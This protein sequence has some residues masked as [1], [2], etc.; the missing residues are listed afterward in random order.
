LRLPPNNR[1][2]LHFG[3][4]VIMLAVNLAV[5][6][7]EEGYTPTK[8]NVNLYTDG[9]ADVEYYLDV[10][11]T[12]I[13]VNVT[14]FGSVYENLMITD[15]G[16]FFLDFELNG[17]LVT[18]DLLGSDSV[19]I[20]YSTSDL[21][22]KTGSMWAI[23][24]TTSME[25]EILLPTAATI[26]N[27]NPVPR[28]IVIVD[29][30]TQLTLPAGDILVSYVQGSVDMSWGAREAR[31]NAEDA[32]KE[33]KI[34]GVAVGDA[35][36][37]FK[38][39]EEAFSEEDY[40]EAQKLFEEAMALALAAKT[41]SEK[42]TIALGLAERA[43]N[44][45]IY[46]NRKSLLKQ[47]EANLDDAYRAYS[48]GDYLLALSMA[49]E[50]SVLAGLSIRPFLDSSNPILLLGGSVALAYMTYKLM[51]RRGGEP[52]E[53][54]EEVQEVETVEVDIELIFKQHPY[55]RL[56]D[57]EVIRF[58]VEVGGGAF[59]AELRQRFDL[60]KSSAWRMIRR[61]ERDGIV[62][63]RAVGR[64]TFVEINRVYSKLLP[65]DIDMDRSFQ[66]VPEGSY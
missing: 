32:I 6:S 13:C 18:V 51:S 45:A 9:S 54:L 26:M 48:S 50:I 60:P 41:N 5:A 17:D 62:V 43:I 42:A 7:A 28:S 55:L 47:A 8:L 14:L 4:L 66:M 1:R 49:E 22:D 10:D 30:R 29:G 23:G 12:P 58:L 56:D 31:I 21:T 11:P 53:D 27:L 65:Q 35:E 25:A 34:E 16:G 57:K 37:T 52:L 39:A 19:K 15:G 36:E 38:A 33:V 59:A 2:R 64:E 24:M 20:F 40:Y 61:L 44:A 46:E 3:L 63:T